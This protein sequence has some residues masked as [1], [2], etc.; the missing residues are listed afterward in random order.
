MLCAA[1]DGD[2][3]AHVRLT[4]VI[5]FRRPCRRCGCVVQDFPQTI[6]IDGVTIAIRMRLAER[7]SMMLLAL[8]VM[9]TFSASGLCHRYR[10]SPPNH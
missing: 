2:A 1:A 5:A 10:C 6:D 7:P 3:F 9:N 8:L 4:I